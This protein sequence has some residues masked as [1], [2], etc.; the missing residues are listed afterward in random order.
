KDWLR[1]HHINVLT[2]PAQLPNLSPIEN[3]WDELD[4]H[5][6]QVDPC[7][8]TLDKLFKALQ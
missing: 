8:E 5:V 3:V 6:H 7:P 2:W 4:N 1:D